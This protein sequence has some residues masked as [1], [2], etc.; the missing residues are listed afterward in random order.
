MNH[1]DDLIAEVALAC[2]V[3][4]SSIMGKDRHKSVALARHYCMYLLRVDRKLSFTEVGRVM[5]DRDHTTVIHAVA[6]VRKLMVDADTQAL[7]WK[8]RERLRGVD[9]SD[10]VPEGVD[11]IADQLAFLQGSGT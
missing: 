3:P 7:I 5:N 10:A 6:R 2:R 9:P 4:A 1:H 8:V 11:S